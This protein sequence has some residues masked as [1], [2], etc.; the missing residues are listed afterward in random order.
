MYY[1][2]AI[3]SF[4]LSCSPYKQHPVPP[5]NTNT[6]VPYQINFP[7]KSFDLPTELK[8]ASG[9]TVTSNPKIISIVQDEEGAIY[10]FDIEKNTISNKIIFL[11]KGDFEGIEA[12]NDSLYYAVKSSGTIYKINIKNGFATPTK[13]S[14][15][16][17]KSYDV[18]GLTY[19]AIS[20]NLLLCC[21]GPGADSNS[22]TRK[23]FTYNI[24]NQ[25]FN[26][27]PYF[28]ITDDLIQNYFKKYPE[29][30]SN[31]ETTHL[32]FGP[33]GIA[34]HPFTKDIYIIASSGKLFIV[35]DAKN[36]TIIHL[37]KIDKKVHPQPEG[38]AF[39][40]KG[41]M[42]ICDEGKKGGAGK[43]SIYYSKK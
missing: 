41:N 28:E 16:L 8:E 27:T 42:Y 26:E 10:N 30:I 1:F 5:K 2:L 43:L 29:A 24:E 19:D 9:L 4:I 33:S 22:I 39:D 17:N 3:C 15:P 40:P 34:I 14:T 37:E 32:R 36:K 23:T 38:I 11:D 12:I 7:D 25:L 13:I 6:N 18:E 31:F 21:K 20:K 35:L